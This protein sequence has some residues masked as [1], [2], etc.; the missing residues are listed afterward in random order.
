M[1]T[2]FDIDI[3]K[4]GGSS[5][6]KIGYDIIIE[7][8]KNKDFLS[9]KQNSTNF[10]K[11]IVVVSAIKDVTDNLI[12]YTKT[13]KS[14]YL[15]IINNKNISLCESLFVMEENIE[16]INEQNLACL[17]EINIISMGETFTAKILNDYLIKNKINS[18]YL[19]AC[20]IISSDTNNT[21]CLFN[22]GKFNIN[23]NGKKIISDYL[24]NYDVIVIPGFRASDPNNKTCLFGRGGSDTTG[25]I[26]ASELNLNEY[27]I[28]TDVNGVYTADPN[29]VKNS[30]II[31][32]ISYN[33]AQEISAMGAS[34]LHPYCIKPCMIKNIPIIIKN[35]FDCNSNYTT[36]KNIS[37]KNQ[38]YAVTNQNNITLFKI[39]SLD[40]WNNSGFVF[41]IFSHFKDFNVDVDI[42]NTSQFDIT[43][44]T[45]NTDNN[46]LE[47][48]KRKLENNYQVNIIRNCNCV[49]VVGENIKKISKLDEIIKIIQNYDIKLTSYSSN[50]MTLSFVLDSLSSN[51]LVIDL[52][53]IIFRE[54]INYHNS[55]NEFSYEKDIWWEKLLY[56]D[57]LDNCEYIYNLDII[58]NKINTLKTLSSISKIY[59][60]MKANFNID[61]LNKIID[62]NLGIETVSIDEI[63][64][65]EN[66]FKKF[67][68]IPILYTP[69]FSKINDY[70]YA[71]TKSN[72]NII[73]DNLLIIEEYPEIFKNKSIG[74][75]L[76]LNYGFGHCDKVITQG[77]DSKFGIEINQL[78][79]NLNLFEKNN[80]SIIGVHSHMGSGI[81]DYKHWINNLSLIL[82]SISKVKSPMNK[83]EWI[84][85]GGG[86]GI[87]D[88][89]NWDE[90]NKEINNINCPY[91]IIIE[92]GRF[93]VAESGIILGKVN[94]IKYKNKTKFIGTNIGM[95]DIIRPALYSAVHPIYF[96]NNDNYI[97]FTKSKQIQKEIVTV[98]GP[99]CES[100]DVLVKNMLAPKNIKINDNVIMTNTGA[101]GFVMSSNYNLRKTPG[102]RL[103]KF[104]HLLNKK[105]ISIKKK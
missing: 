77:N 76:D 9:V 100:G 49:S 69:N 66:N 47:E 50:D 93:I 40:M 90:L 12:E 44:T 37:S 4:L 68:M 95:N 34:I 46:I 8:S 67:S 2:N 21:D 99:V 18:A 105:I 72:I 63:Y 15:D 57:G 73:I 23:D 61:I 11:L 59:Y 97:H 32:N 5:Q 52:H 101:Y 55:I 27:K 17:S 39:K 104:I 98:V 103:F 24:N 3:I 62:N 31:N 38:I 10:N 13:K 33:A 22:K 71:F 26:I 43:T 41:D 70:I 85:I 87:D 65:L 48:L 64:Y 6:T 53:D 56:S 30:M 83:I 96:K 29:I 36:I 42:I 45:K 102:E 86:F 79:D 7:K 60:A 58:Q 74:I 16:L 84:D 78:I 81:T 14:Y 75:R 35:T 19:D 89:I 94:Q 1:F 82:E 28:F 80:I 91:K 92:P 88:V 20:E 25:S 54:K 51:D